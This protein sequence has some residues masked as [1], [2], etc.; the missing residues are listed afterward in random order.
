MQVCFSLVVK[1]ATLAC[2]FNVKQ[3]VAAVFAAFALLSCWPWLCH[4]AESLLTVKTSLCFC[5][6][7]FLVQFKQSIWWVKHCCSLFKVAQSRYEVNQQNAGNGW[8]KRLLA[9]SLTIDLCCHNKMSLSNELGG[10]WRLMHHF[11]SICAI[12]NNFVDEEMGL[13]DATDQNDFLCLH[14]AAVHNLLMTSWNHRIFWIRQLW[15][16]KLKNAYILLVNYQ[17]NKWINSLRVTYLHQ[18]FINELHCS[19]GLPVLATEC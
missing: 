17:T 1:W 12:F 11:L 9:E 8:H 16:Q 14:S 2:S 15:Q 4:H 13:L 3:F 19:G 6:L 18:I 7:L 10:H 5:W